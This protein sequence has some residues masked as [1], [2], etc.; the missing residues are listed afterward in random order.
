MHRSKS[1][2]AGKT[3]LRMSVRGLV[4][5]IT[6]EEEAVAEHRVD[7]EA[8]SLDEPFETRV[9]HLQ[10]LLRIGV[11]IVGDD[12]VFLR[13]EY[14]GA[15]VRGQDQRS[16]GLL[17]RYLLRVPFRT[18]GAR[19][20]SVSTMVAVP[21]VIRPASSF[22]SPCI[23]I[24]GIPSASPYRNTYQSNGAVSERFGARNRSKTRISVDIPQ[25]SGRKRSRSSVVLTSCST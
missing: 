11:R 15:S 13:P 10:D 23:L 18:F 12:A 16:S 22:F 4:F 20:Y 14:A 19:T 1:D 17:P 21:A 2:F 9:V 25:K 5:Q 8:D 7:I 6:E 3:S 24:H